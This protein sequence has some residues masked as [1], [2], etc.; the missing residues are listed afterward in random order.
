MCDP[1]VRQGSSLSEVVAETW[2]ASDL[3]ASGPPWAPCRQEHRAVWACTGGGGLRT[4]L[5]TTA[6]TLP[7][8][9]HSPV[10]FEAV[11]LKVSKQALYFYTNY[12]QFKLPFQFARA[13]W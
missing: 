2:G 13:E 1:Q 8:S 10:Q 3:M 11:A 9:L 6:L 4:E 12:I 5:L 7:S